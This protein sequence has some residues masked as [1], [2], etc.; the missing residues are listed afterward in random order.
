MSDLT[1]EIHSGDVLDGDDES[2]WYHEEGITIFMT[3]EVA[4]V[5]CAWLHHSVRVTTAQLPD[6][7]I[8]DFMA[9]LNQS[10]PEN[11]K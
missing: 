1:Y 10:I 8:M 6:K 7:S 11:N 5:L 9:D 4:I 3:Y 2:P